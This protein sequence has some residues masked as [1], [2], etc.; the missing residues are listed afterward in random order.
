[1]SKY[2]ARVLLTGIGGDDLFCSQLSGA[3]LAADS[4]RNFDLRTAHTQLL[5]WSSAYEIPYWQLLFRETIP[6][7]LLPRLVTRI[8]SSKFLVPQ[9]STKLVARLNDY[10]SPRTG[11]TPSDLWRARSAQLLCSSLSSGHFTEFSDI[12]VSHPYT[13]RPL[14]E[15]CLRVPSSQFVRKGRTRSLLRR[16]LRNLLPEKLLRRR[17]KSS[18]DEAL[19]RAI[20]RE[21]S[22]IGNLAKWRVCQREYVHLPALQVALNESKCGIISSTGALFPIFAL[23]RWLR[24]LEMIDSTQSLVCPGPIMVHKL[25]ANDSHSATAGF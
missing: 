15:F 14:L 12:Y 16:A 18:L 6:F 19:L 17:G 25:P 4:I 11:N 8:K 23:E 22:S 3:I 1:M 10:S 13:H 2:G 24:S 21:W 5:S 20:Q 9:H 7:A